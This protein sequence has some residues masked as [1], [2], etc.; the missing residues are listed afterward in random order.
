MTLEF[1]KKHELLKK[2]RA[3]IKKKRVILDESK[4]FFGLK[5]LE[6]IT[7]VSNTSEIKG[8]PLRAFT[9]LDIDF[10][11][12]V[13]PNENKY[14]KSQDPTRLEYL[15]L[16]DTTINVIDTGKSPHIVYY[17]GAQK[18]SNKAKAIGFLKV[19]QLEDVKPQS[20][21]IISEYINGGTLSSWSDL[22][23]DI[24]PSQ[25]KSIV[26]QIIYT[27]AIL[28]HDYRMMHNDFH[29]GN[30]LMDTE[31]ETQPGSYFVYTINDETFYILNTGVIP[32][33]F[34][35]EFCMVYSNKIPDF[36]ENK[37]VTRY[38]DYNPITFTTTSWSSSSSDDSSDTDGNCIPYNYNEVYDL[39]YFLCALFD[40]YISSELYEWIMSIYP[41]ELIPEDESSVETDSMSGDSGSDSMNGS[42]SRDDGSRDDGNGSR[43]DGSRDDGSD[44]SEL[45]SRPGSGSETET[46]YTH[47]GRIING[48]EKG[49]KNLPTPKT[50]L[51]HKFFQEFKTKPA[52]FNKDVS[53]FFDSKI[54][55]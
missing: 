15:A 9:D 1:N 44:G 25:W 6:S 32:K 24:T 42:R 33:I 55:R 46:I 47:R 13:I 20:I 7:S 53:Y 23:E 17:L 28:Q 38:R 18:V 19:D 54:K 48:M 50:I 11:L 31:I 34:D 30:I 43:S 8:Y 21:M 37:L 41:H 16:K 39:H 40:K 27:I 22:N 49:F 36:Y 4:S 26:F 10:G 35:F 45:S 3:D 52:D 5:N 29:Y 51:T 2:I 12:K 14:S